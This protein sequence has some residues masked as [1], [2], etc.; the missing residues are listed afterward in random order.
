[1]E[2]RGYELENEDEDEDKVDAVVND[3]RSDF[4]DVKDEGN[5]RER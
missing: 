4:N 1:M 5:I 2:L 3:D